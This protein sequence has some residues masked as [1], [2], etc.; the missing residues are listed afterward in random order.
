VGSLSFLGLGVQP[1]APDWGLM[2]AENR[3]L[4]SIA[5]L[6]TLAPAV[7]ICMLSISFNLLADAVSNHLSRGESSKMVKL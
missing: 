6:A 2:V 1:P 5:P 4:L 3:S 7:A